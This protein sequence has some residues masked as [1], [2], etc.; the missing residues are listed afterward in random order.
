MDGPPLQPLAAAADVGVKGEE[1]AQ[2]SPDGQATETKQSQPPLPSRPA[3]FE[4]HPTEAKTL[5][6]SAALWALIDKLP[7]DF[8]PDPVLMLQVMDKL[9]PEA[10]TQLFVK[11]KEG[12]A[13]SAKLLRLLKN[14]S[15]GVEQLAFGGGGCCAFGTPVPTAPA[16]DAE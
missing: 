13:R 8:T 10:E 6:P 12:D 5:V 15:R 11:A 14:G 3:F 1:D 16:A 7:E 2:G 4:P 9:T